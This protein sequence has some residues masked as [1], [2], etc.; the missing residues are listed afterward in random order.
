MMRRYGVIAVIL[1]FGLLAGALRSQQSPAS[2]DLFATVNTQA[3]ARSFPH[4]WEQMFGSGRAVL[5]L[6]DDYR[7][8]LRMVR[9]ITSFRYIRF[10]G[11]FD[12]DVGVYQKDPQGRPVYNWGRVCA[13]YWSAPPTGP[14]LHDHVVVRDQGHSGCAAQ[15][16]LACFHPFRDVGVARQGIGAA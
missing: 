14:P 8:D 11:I 5:S 6:R 7:R 13:A 3:E 4:F 1:S 16:V 9:E 10:H 2:G 12:E 15:D